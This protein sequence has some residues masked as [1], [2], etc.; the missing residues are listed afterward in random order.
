MC[1]TKPVGHFTLCISHLHCCFKVNLCVKTSLSVSAFLFFSL[2]FSLFTLSLLSCFRS[3]S[4]MTR[5]NL[6]GHGVCDKVQMFVCVCVSPMQVK[7]RSLSTVL[8]LG[9]HHTPAC[10]PPVQPQ[11]I[12][13]SQTH[14]RTHKYS[15]DKKCTH[16][17]MCTDAPTQTDSS[18]KVLKTYINISRKL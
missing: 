5:V 14:T 4:W 10:L 1:P 17:Q 12:S 9:H 15:Q 13:Q 18:F 16:T 2:L 11:S 3:M 6:N 7:Y 8:P